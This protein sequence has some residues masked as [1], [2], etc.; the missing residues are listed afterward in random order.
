[1]TAD[2]IISMIAAVG[3]I[4]ASL[5]VIIARRV[6]PSWK[7][8]VLILLSCADVTLAHA[9]QG[10]NFDFATKVF[11]YKMCIL[12][13]TI[14]PTAFFCLTLRYGG[15]GN[16]LTTR[17]L[18]MLS[19]FPALSAGLILTNEIHGLVW[20][21]ASI[22]RI[23]NITT[24]V[25][26]TDAR[27]WYWLFVAYSYL[28]MGV[29]CFFL[30]RLLILSHGI[31]G[32]Q[33]GAVVFAAILALLGVLLDFLVMSPLPPFAATALGMAAGSITVAFLLPSLRRR[34]LIYISRRAII[35]S[36]SDSIMVVDGENR[37]VEMNPS[38]EKLISEL[39]SQAIGKHIDQ[40][41]PELSSHWIHNA[42]ISS[43]VTLK[44]GETTY[45]FDLH[46]SI[47]HD[48]QGHIAGRSIDLHDI[49]DRKRAEEQVRTLNEELEFRVIERTKQLEAANKELEAFA[50]S[51]AHDL[52]APLRAI[53]GFAHI[54]LE[55]YENL[56]GKEGKRL[57]TIIYGES[58]Q[59]GRLIDD[60]L[61]FSHISHTEIQMTL[62]DM[63]DLV[64]S[65]FYKLSTPKSRERI[66][67]QVGPLPK[68]MSDITLI[69]EVWLN[70]ISNAIKFSSKRERAII[71]V[72]YLQEGDNIIYL[73]RDNG[74]G[75][76]MRYAGKLF[77]IFWRMH[78]DK[79]FEGTG[80]G[81]AIVQRLIRR[82]GGEVW[83][84]SEVDKGATFYFT[85][86][87][88][89]SRS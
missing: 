57:C 47:I 86:P 74:A 29:G 39:A 11:W 64:K 38:A 49:S 30:I 87:Q 32:W 1:M 43:E 19:V 25:S 54:L 88:K 6:R 41:L 83:A 9:L 34:D 69:S 71:E 31:Y 75:F 80:I 65:I 72:S 76:D 89:R 5:Y 45:I 59:M 40:F 4:L 79:E 42:N 53:D 73:V 37:I 12:G 84:E 21:P 61:A 52:R 33:A 22:A 46:V 13:F 82:H 78:S 16:I 68:T 67:F 58:Q 8:G 55:D 27:I 17:T 28:L 18:V 62:I 20:N 24:F 85:L 23:V 10:I 48:W 66:D 36:I 2:I 3:F 14:T 7:A 60:L 15:W 77:T 51:V 63:E 26:I 81:L 56:L 50:Y 35:D 70:L 44:R